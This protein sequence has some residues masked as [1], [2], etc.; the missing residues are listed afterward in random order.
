MQKRVPHNI[1]RNLACAAHHQRIMIAKVADVG[2]APNQRLH[3]NREGS[4]AGR[5][6][7]FAQITG[8]HKR[9]LRRRI[10]DLF[11][12]VVVNRLNLPPQLADFLLFVI[13]RKNFLESFEGNHFRREFVTPQR[14][15]E[16]RRWPADQ[17]EPDITR[18]HLPRVSQFVLFIKIPQHI[19]RRALLM[20]QSI[21]KLRAHRRPVCRAD[22]RFES[23]CQQ[24]A[25]RGEHRLA[26]VHSDRR[27]RRGLQLWSCLFL[28]P[29]AIGQK[30]RCAQ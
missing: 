12:L 15:F 9:N 2:D 18:K 28:C 20:L 19:H 30:Q 25:H 24:R 17:T 7:N 29:R 10:V 1:Q 6:K 11:D 13:I 5:I 26:A 21:A 3:N 16:F 27:D 22:V 14:W 23:R 8:G 4:R